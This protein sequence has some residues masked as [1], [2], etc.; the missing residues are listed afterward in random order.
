MA[1]RVSRRDDDFSFGLLLSQTPDGFPG[2]TERV[3]PN[4]DGHQQS[5]QTIKAGVVVVNKME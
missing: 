1:G 4:D 5:A 3:A 2:L